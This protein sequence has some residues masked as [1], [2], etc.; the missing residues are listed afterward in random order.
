[1]SLNE[2]QQ[3]QHKE[4]TAGIQE[5]GFRFLNKQIDRE[6]NHQIKAKLQSF[7][8]YCLDQEIL[9]EIVWDFEDY[10]YFCKSVHIAPKNRM[11]VHEFHTEM[12][13]IQDNE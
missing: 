13:D 10:F 2:Q 4:C 3:K 11:I 9:P 1:M 6:K 12:Q 7:R 8:D 5:E